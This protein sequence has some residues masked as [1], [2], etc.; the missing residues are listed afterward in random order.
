MSENRSQDDREELLFQGLID[1]FRS[2]ASPI[3]PLEMLDML[4]VKT[5]DNLT[6]R[7]KEVLENAISEIRNYRISGSEEM[8]LHLILMFQGAAMQH[9]GKLQNPITKKIER[10]I[11]AAR[12]S[13][14]T[15]RM[16]EAKTKD[17]LSDEESKLLSHILF[18]LQLNY[19]DEVEKDKAKLEGR[20]PEGEPERKGSEDRSEKES[21]GEPEKESE[22]ESEGDKEEES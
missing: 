9:M 1:I 14:D 15:L 12:D 11:A 6:E 16:L 8:L 5:G 3:D 7:Q 2:Y 22:D 21:K 18:E 19:V 10:D 4:K 13:I 20:E 17:N